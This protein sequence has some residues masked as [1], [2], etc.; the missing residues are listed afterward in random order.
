MT[1]VNAETGEVVEAAVPIESVVFDI[2]IYPRAEWSARTVERYADA[3]RAGEAL[4]PIVLEDGTD[5]LLDGLHRWKAHQAVEASTIEVERHVVPDGVPVKLYAASLSA[6]H[7]DRMT[8]DDLRASA[9]DAVAR[10]PEMSQGQIARLLGVSSATVSRWCSDISEHRRQVRQVKALLL[11]RSGMTQREA[12]KFLEV[13]HKTVGSDLQMEVPPHIEDL[14]P[15]ALD[16]LPPECEAEADKLV[17]ELVFAKW[18]AEERKLLKR[19]QAG[20]TIVVNQHR[21]AD[22]IRWAESAGVYVKVDRNSNWGNPFVLPDD[23]DRDTVIGAYADH[24]LPH[25]PSLTNRIPKLR[26]KVL[27][28]W[29]HPEACH[30]DVLAAEAD[31]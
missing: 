18:T 5:R 22:L 23:G 30:G 15:E 21:H 20:H 28:C 7:G 10:N 29:C 13:D 17:A 26:G 25:K 1:L 12:G 19:H 2:S 8:G 11:T 16:G 14:L 27:G 24:Y 4:P 9:R 31:R 6:R 3:I